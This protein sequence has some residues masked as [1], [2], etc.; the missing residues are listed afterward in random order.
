MK[1]YINA[2][3]HE[4]AFDRIV[5]SI[6]KVKSDSDAE[7][8]HGGTYDKSVGY[9]ISPTVV[10]TL[11]PNYFSMEQ[12]LFGPLVTVYTYSDDKWGGNPQVS[13]FYINL[14]AYRGDFLRGSL[15]N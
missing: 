15:C 11:N 8:F 12:E 2:V 5:K 6:E 3:I 10:T 1:N 14:C 9:F 4:E 7:I 13:R